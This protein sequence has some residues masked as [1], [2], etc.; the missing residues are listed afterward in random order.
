MALYRWQM[1]EAATREMQ[2]SQTEFTT[3]HGVIVLGTITVLAV[4]VLWLV[5]EGF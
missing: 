2:L 5:T 3:R 4:T 1:K